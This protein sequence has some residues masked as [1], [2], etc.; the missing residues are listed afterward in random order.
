ME[1]WDDG[2]YTKVKEQF[3]TV[4]ET[5]QASYSYDY[6]YQYLTLDGGSTRYHIKLYQDNTADC[7]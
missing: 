5:D 1:A 6:R 7:Q 4:Y 2:G 3:T